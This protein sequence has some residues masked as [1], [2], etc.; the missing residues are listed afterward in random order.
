[1]NN[2][3]ALL[4]KRGFTLIEALI[5]TIIAGYCILP[6]MGTL[7]SGMEKT[8]SFDHREKLRILARSRLNKEISQAAFDHAA[9]DTSTVFHY[10]YYDNST[11]P[12]LLTTDSL[13]DPASFTENTATVSS[14]LFGYRVSVAIDENLKLATTSLAIDEK[15]IVGLSG[16]K[17]ITVFAE[18][19]TAPQSPDLASES[20]SLFSLLNIPS[21]SDDYIW[22]SNPKNVEI[23]AIDPISRT[24]AD[25]F[26]LP[27]DNTA[28]PRDD[29][30]ND[31]ARPWNIAVHPNQRFIV[32]QCKHKIKAL[33]IDR[34]SP[35]YGDCK[36]IWPS[37]SINGI[38]NIGVYAPKLADV[39]KDDKNKAGEDRS[40]TFRPDGKFVYVAAHDEKKI[41]AFLAS[42]TTNWN[43][44]ALLNQQSFETTKDKNTVLHAGRD[45][46]LYIGPK[47]GNRAIRF[48]MYSDKIFA[49]PPH[50]ITDASNK[51][52]L[53]LDTTPDG[54]EFYIL[55]A[56]NILT[57]HKS[58]T[59]KRIG[60]STITPTP[61]GVCSDIKLSGDGR[62]LGIVDAG[63]GADKGGFFLMHLQT[64]PIISTNY[65]LTNTSIFKKADP[66]NLGKKEKLKYCL[67]VPQS[68]DFVIDEE[69]KPFL[70]AVDLT[71][72][73][74]NLYTSGIP[75]DRTINF[76]P[77][78][79]SQVNMT[80][81]T[82]EYVLVGSVDGGKNFIE[83]V[84][85]NSMTE[86]D[87]IKR[88]P[89]ENLRID[90][91]TTPVCIAISRSGEKMRVG[92][93]PNR[94]GLDIFETWGARTALNAYPHGAQ[95]MYGVATPNEDLMIDTTAE[96]FMSMDYHPTTGWA[97]GYWA[98]IPL[99]SPLPVGYK[100]PNDV[101]IPTGWRGHD[102]EAL[103]NGGFLIL[104]THNTSKASMLEW[105]G[106]HS[107]GPYK[108]KY[109]R[110]ARWY[111]TENNFPPHNSLNIA[112]SA[113]DR[114]LAIESSG[115]PNV[116][117][118]YDFAAN[119]FNWQTQ[120]NGLLVDYREQNHEPWNF[121]KVMASC[122]YSLNN[123][124]L[125]NG[126]RLQNSSTENDS[127]VSHQTSPANY[128]FDYSNALLPNT[129]H[130]NKSRANKRFIGYFKPDY[131]ANML[132]I[133][134]M[135]FSRLFL[136]FEPV[137]E[138]P[139]NPE[140]IL[141]TAPGISA[142]SQTPIQLD[143]C[144]AQTTKIKM[145]CGTAVTGWDADISSA[146]NLCATSDP[147]TNL[148]GIPAALYQTHRWIDGN[149]DYNFNWIPDGP[150]LVKLHFNE[151]FFDAVNARKFH[152]NIEGVTR[153]TEFDI[154]QRAGGKNIALVM[155]Y[156]NVVVSGGNGLQIKLLK[157]SVNNPCICGIEIQAGGA[158]YMGMF[159]H[160]TA[161]QAV[162]TLN[163][164]VATPFESSFMSMTGWRNI[165]S[166]S[167]MPFSFQPTFL[168]AYPITGTS[169][170][171]LTCMQFSRDIAD[172][173]LY[174]LDG[175]NDAVWCL[176]PG[177]PI[178]RINLAS[179]DI[180]DKQLLISQ[181]GQKLIYAREDANKE[182]IIVDISEPESFNFNGVTRNQSA[183]TGFGSI[184][185]VVKMQGA[186][187]V[188]ANMPFN[189]IKSTPGSGTYE[190]VAT[191]SIDIC[192]VN[193]AAVASG[194]IY[195]LGGSTLE[196][197]AATNTIFCFNPL[198]SP[199]GN[200]TPLVATLP[201]KINMHTVVAYD[202]EL[203][204]FNGF[205]GN[206]GTITSLV[207][208]FNPGTGK[209]LAYQEP[210]TGAT[211]E[212]RVS[213][214]MTGSTVPAPYKVTHTGSVHSYG[215]LP[216]K[217]QEG[218]KAFD[219]D[220]S[221]GWSSTANN[222]SIT[223][224]FGSAVLAPIVTK[225][226]INNAQ[227]DPKD[228]VK[229]FKFEGSHDNST[230]HL[231][232][233]DTAA[234][235]Q[236]A[237]PCQ[238][239]NITA[240]RYYR[241]TILSN[242]GG[243]SWA[244]REL[245]LIAGNVRKISPSNMTSNIKDG[246]TVSASAA[247]AGA[248]WKAFD[249]NANTSNEWDTDRAVPASGEWHQIDLGTADNINIVR[250]ICGPGNDKGIKDFKLQGATSLS[251]SSGADT[252]GGWTD[253]PCI[254]GGVS[255]QNP[256]NGVWNTFYFNNTS[257]YRY[258]RL[259]CNSSYGDQ[260]EVWEIEYYSTQTTVP[261]TNQTFMTRTM[262]D[263]LSLVKVKENAACVTPYGIVV[264]GGVVDN[265]RTTATSTSLVYWPHGYHE[266]N[267]ANDFSLGISRSLPNMVEPV[268]DHCL[269]W[270]KGMVYRVGGANAA[271]TALS[272]YE[273]FNFDT[274]TWLQMTVHSAIRR[275]KAAAC[276]HGDEIFIFGGRSGGANIK[277][278]YAWNP[279]TNM[280][281][282][283]ADVPKAA[284]YSMTAVSCG[285]SIYLI[286]G[287]DSGTSGPSRSIWKFT[288]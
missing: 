79:K 246:K 166:A 105:V 26:L 285:S 23:I 273:R 284:A 53:A 103:K 63:S 8:Q 104:Y 209:V 165:A 151:N 101:D 202:N 46:W 242:H 123:P 283:I 286:G 81:R 18:I 51:N 254:A 279:E 85:I 173:I 32:I 109:E 78:D 35:N 143:I 226:V 117:R 214:K 112:L 12:Q 217:Y 71:G 266:Y 100:S 258:Y 288:P 245:Q 5:A 73:K 148:N 70:F 210:V 76:A 211:T 57:R 40:I 1:M 259:L 17:A 168:R 144:R 43:N 175:T 249:G 15:H 197:A 91:A 155:V 67:F 61:S 167:T 29:S 221:V 169:N 118:I 199:T 16:L 2:L 127:W 9:I 183:L 37:Y 88:K 59:G 139:V 141:E 260:L 60:I 208:K 153:E 194:G 124:S 152:I 207:Q 193:N 253:I 280:V 58:D 10:V 147:V 269:V 66:N 102:I 161:G 171:I 272:E 157:G 93:G 270:H 115:S 225:L 55:W 41:F 33:N 223:Y 239:T 80:V 110:F 52:I 216:V 138:N 162:G 121:N 22:L 114:Y 261:A 39:N 257:N 25:S 7:Q 276:S 200:I 267:S 89:T 56:D 256:S 96:M 189:T 172:P 156:D 131:T 188:L 95:W 132:S 191:L 68:G 229:T 163:K 192:G 158:S 181:D 20:I 190:C 212:F 42:N 28:K 106:K 282:Q 268:A 220:T 281:R 65:N 196:N 82:P 271:G 274:N 86:T 69:K 13:I 135:D 137:V 142:G 203:Y 185:G 244:I 125:L 170:S 222:N 230:W 236:T 231:L 75:D 126:I 49:N 87:P 150:A 145:Y 62:Y 14:L 11:E 205:D 218:W 6:I 154:L 215:F 107:F 164:T 72:L 177:K 113:D 278:A 250:I 263:N 186:P 133:A 45:G 213:S 277:T 184:A 248:A 255:P 201:R 240:Y 262:T 206:I 130:A 241:F 116:I 97:N 180:T 77:S 3:W 287:S 94:A 38:G 228:G 136:N 247:G 64:Q 99:P 149:L 19:A 129:N 50:E 84:D 54:Q 187:K 238:V 74:N 204:A 160:Q 21:F 174:I 146:G 235:N 140:T 27:L 119:D 237:W 251:S 34:T 111:S 48:P 224:D 159:T 122:T 24:K 47:D 128:Y 265:P 176:K 219:H 264:A 90:L 195:I 233:S 178:T 83:Y 108:G 36:V 98:N 179:I 275:H 92:Y 182:T 234:Q 31:G 227:T 252:T 30:S 134:Q 198:A 120:L 232:K 243:S 44:L 4:K